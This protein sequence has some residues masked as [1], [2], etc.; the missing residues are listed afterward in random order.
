MSNEF[1]SIWIEVVNPIQKNTLIGGF[2][3]Q[4]TSEVCDKSEAEEN[5]MIILLDQ[6]E[7][8]TN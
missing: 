3:R 5:G 1:P 8:A 6:I 2:Y 7:K 4:W